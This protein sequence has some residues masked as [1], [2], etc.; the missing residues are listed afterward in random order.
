VL[1]P[2]FPVR[3]L[4]VLVLVAV[5]LGGGWVW[6]RDSSLVGVKTVYVTGVSSSEG[7][8]VRA[9][10]QAAALDMTTLNVRTEELRDAVASFASVADVRAQ[11]DFPHKLTVE[12]VEREPVAVVQLA[13][14]R[15]PV[16]AGGRLMRG[17]RPAGDL[18]V[19]RA[20]RL[21]PG[22]LITDRRALGAVEVLSGAPARLRARVSRAFS[23][24]RGLT[25][26]MRNGPQ[27]IFGS[28]NE[29]ERKWLAA[30]RVL[31]DPS[32]AGAVYLDLRVPTRVAAG[33]LGPVPETPADALTVNSQVQQSNPQPQ[34]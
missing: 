26:D 4:A 31:A 18:P 13:G 16:G 5:V 24:P 10:L 25:L 15:V 23:G 14:Q 32:A 2:R 33:G 3:L 9:A 19:V 17:V 30:A 28:R 34:P 29:L 20:T 6:L 11:A 21:A 27:L 7:R 12:V 1:R 8:Q 22:D